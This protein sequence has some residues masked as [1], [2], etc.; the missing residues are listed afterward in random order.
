MY[1]TKLVRAT[2]L[3]SGVSALVGCLTLLPAR[4]LL[5]Q[6]VCLSVSS[7][8]PVWASSPFVSGQSGIFTAVADATPLSAGTDSA[9]GLSL[10]SQSTYAGLAAIARFNS[11]GYLD[12][13]NGS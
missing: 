3:L 4:K 11:A 1:R 13:R 2:I 10:G 7:S 6:G 12:A 9:V 5:S 8:G